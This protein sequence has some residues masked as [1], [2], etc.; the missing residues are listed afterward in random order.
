[1][2]KPLFF[3]AAFLFF[4]C[5]VACSDKEESQTYH[6]SGTF[7]YDSTSVND[8]VCVFVD[9]HFG[10]ECHMVPS[11]KGA[12]SFQGETSSLDELT[13][14]YNHQT[15][16][17][18]A[19]P[20]SNISFQID[21]LG[22]ISWQTNDSINA[23]LQH[24]DGQL[25]QK[26]AE[27]RRLYVDSICRLGKDQLR[28]ALLLREQMQELNDSLFVR[29]CLGSL[30]EQAKPDWLVR[31]LDDQFDR[32]SLQTVRAR[33]L[34]REVLKM[35]NDSSYALLDSRQESLLI[36]FWADY[37]SASIDSLHL[38]SDIARDYGLYDFEENFANEKSETRSKNVHRIELMTVCIHHTDSGSWKKTIEGLPGKHAW[39]K[40]GFAHPLL[41][42]FNIT[43]LP[44]NLEADRFSNIQGQNRWTVKLRGWLEN[45]PSR[46]NPKTDSKSSASAKA[47]TKNTQKPKNSSKSSSSST[48]RKELKTLAN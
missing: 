17:A 21:S 45:T 48:L 42:N 14:S 40:G 6:L 44:A 3:F 36:F 23:W 10:V 27:A 2:R 9:D 46:F 41:A 24:H 16:H 20:G 25:T 11:V 7:G 35:A 29:R 30:S 28:S 26:S 33:R 39:I 8:T 22:T 1:M 34:P 13:L 31:I 5:F 43:S 47:T 19:T 12:F 4:C 32:L 38:L 15:V 18:Y 37:D